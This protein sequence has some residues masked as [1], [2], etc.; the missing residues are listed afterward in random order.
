LEVE[1]INVNNLL[2]IAAKEEGFENFIRQLPLV[3]SQT[4]K[5]EDTNFNSEITNDLHT[6]IL[7]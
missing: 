1:E 5:K 2:L 3:T 6:L 7:F 4:I